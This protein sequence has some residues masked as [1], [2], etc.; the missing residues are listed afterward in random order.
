MRTSTINKNTRIMSVEEFKKFM[1]DKTVYHHQ[2]YWIE[3]WN[4][5]SPITDYFP[6]SGFTLSK[7]IKLKRHERYN[8][9]KILSSRTTSG[10]GIWDLNR[11]TVSIVKTKN[12]VKYYVT[13]QQK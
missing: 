7:G 1:S 8:N 4:G 13:K 9:P 2:C 12:T 10:K 6:H 11:Y 5:N 3:K